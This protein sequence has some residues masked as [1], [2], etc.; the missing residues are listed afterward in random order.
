MSVTLNHFTSLLCCSNSRRI[1]KENGRSNRRVIKKKVS[2]FVDDN[3]IPEPDIALELG[4]SM[5]LIEATEKEAAR[6]VHVTHERIVIESDPK[7]ARRRP[8]GIAFRDTSGVSKKMTPDLS[9]KLKGVLT[10]TPKEK[11]AADTMQ[12]LKESKKYSRSQ[13]LT[14]GSSEGTSVSLGVP[15]ESIVIPT[16]SSEGTSTKPVVL[17]EKKDEVKKDDDDIDDD[18]SINLKKTNDEETDDEFLH[19]EEQVNDDEDE[20]MSDAE[21]RDSE[22]SD[23]EITDP[24]K[25]DAQK[26][27]EVKNDVK[28]AELPPSGSS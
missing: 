25:A 22:K 16:T 3:I 10:L 9:Q 2:I 11:L 8:L 24:A 26:A 27:E 15:D 6:Q 14:G 18:K 5:S 23:E 19:G 4:K 20:E 21:V 28:K 1:K 7:P 13:S 17:D 12:T